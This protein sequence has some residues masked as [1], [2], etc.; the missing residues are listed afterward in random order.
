M[1]GRYGIKISQNIIRALLLII[2]TSMVAF[3]LMKASPGRSPAGERR[4]GRAGEHESGADRET[5]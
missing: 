2:L 4:A 5:A 3:A 1:K